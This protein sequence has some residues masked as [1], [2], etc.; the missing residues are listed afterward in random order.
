MRTCRVHLVDV[1]RMAK[2][3]ITGGVGYAARN[4]ET[5]GIYEY[6]GKLSRC[7]KNKRNVQR[8]RRHKHKNGIKITP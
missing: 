7:S 3:I 8:S 4:N 5:Q 1:L 6:A 2:F